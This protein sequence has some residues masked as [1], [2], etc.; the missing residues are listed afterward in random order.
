MRN[1]SIQGNDKTLGKVLSSII[2]LPA[3]I[4][5]PGEDTFLMLDAL[6]NIPI[7]KKTVL[8]IG[9]GSGILGLFAALRG[10]A[11]TIADISEEAL[12]HASEAAQKLG[13]SLQAVRSD[14]FS[15]IKGRFDLVLF[16]PPY[17]PSSRLEDTAVDGGKEGASLTRRFLKKLPTHLNRDGCALL[18]LSSQNNPTSLIEEHQEFDFTTQARL[19]L[20]FE[21][22][23]VL[24]VKP[25]RYV[26]R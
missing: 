21:E 9:T 12:T 19:P 6:S 25:R 2:P 14:L 3:A 5:S 23:Q 26:A 20:F 10:A 1:P 11:V 13:V 22:V 8:D 7:E 18:L 17:L 24:R 15:D 4:Y 16:N